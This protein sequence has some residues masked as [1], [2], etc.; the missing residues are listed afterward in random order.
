MTAP[1]ISFRPLKLTDL[2]L[3]H[4]WLTRPHV[5]EW[6]TPAPS[7]EQVEEE[8]GPLT[9]ESSTTRPYLVLFDG[10]PGGFIQSYVAMGSGDGWWE[11][12]QDPGVRG[13]DQFLAE[14]EQL[15]LGLG[16][17]MVRAFVEYLFA[18]SAVSCIQTDPSPENGRAIRCYEKAGFRAT[19][20]VDTPDG[21]ALLMV[22]EREEI[23]GRG[24][25]LASGGGRS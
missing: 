5:V 24:V 17:A 14:A 16:T 11:D 1:A 23:A 18:D 20:V 25:P 12:E 8:F 2:R 19:R 7:L 4:E 21:P 22:C 15:G 13:I 10:I 6:W 3:L 9:S